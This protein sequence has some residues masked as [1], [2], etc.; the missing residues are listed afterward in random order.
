MCTTTQNQTLI[1]FLSILPTLHFQISHSV[2]EWSNSSSLRPRPSEASKTRH[3]WSVLSNLQ[4][5]S[6]FHWKCTVQQCDWWD[7]LTAACWGSWRSFGR[8]KANPR[9][10]RIIIFPFWA[11]SLMKILPSSFCVMAKIYEF[12]R[13][14]GK[15]IVPYR[16]LSI[17]IK[18]EGDKVILKGPNQPHLCFCLHA[19]IG[20]L[21][22]IRGLSKQRKIIVERLK[23]IK[24]TFWNTAYSK[25]IRIRFTM[26]DQ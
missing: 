2:L 1:H 23:I 26:L 20:L 9:R 10:E 5:F 16:T 24:H 22:F 4:H 3:L 18:Q 21:Y 6:S 14:N 7:H 17:T 13:L 19:R 12:Y 15:N 8:G 11:N 25:T